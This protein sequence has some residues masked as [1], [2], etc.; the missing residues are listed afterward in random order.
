MK[1]LR[2][3][4][5]SVGVMA[6][7]G[8]GAT[9]AT[10]SPT[11]VATPTTDVAA[12]RTAAL[13]MFFFQAPGDWLPCS[14]RTP[15][16]A[17]ASNFA[18]CPFSATVKARLADVEGSNDFTSAPGGRCGGDY[19]IGTTNPLF[20]VPEVLS[21]VAEGNGSV[22]VVIQRVLSVPNLTAVMTTTNGTWLATDLASGTGP[23]ASIFSAKPNC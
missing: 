22:T 19:I 9:T 15:T 14:A 6:L 12:A 3:L 16:T 18:D 23:S 7:V 1:V 4:F 8:C 2:A 20:A 21:A 5:A 17:R 11:P 13:T 10:T